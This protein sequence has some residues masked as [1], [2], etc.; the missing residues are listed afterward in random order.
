VKRAVHQLNMA[1]VWCAVTVE[2]EVFVMTYAEA[3][4]LQF[5]SSRRECL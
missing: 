3:F 4:A 2:A 5:A 1:Y